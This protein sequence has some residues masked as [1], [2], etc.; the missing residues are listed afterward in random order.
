MENQIGQEM[1]DEM[2]ALFYGAITN[3]LW[4]YMALKAYTL[5]PKG[6]LK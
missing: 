6:Y 3:I 2:E 4:F 5:K 1:K